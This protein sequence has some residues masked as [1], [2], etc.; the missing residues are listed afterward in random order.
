MS[1]VQQVKKIARGASIYGVITVF[2]LVLLDG[3]LVL[4]GLFEP[5]SNYG[6]P[7]VG[8]V[9]VTPT[10]EMETFPCFDAGSGVT[11]P[12]DRNERGYRTS[13]SV[14]DLAAENDW[15]E[16]AVSGDSHTDQCMT[17]EEMH[18]GVMADELTALGTESVVFSYGAGRYS[19]LQ[20]YLAVREGVEDFAPDA[21]VINLYTGNDFYDILRVDDRPHFVRV[22]EG[23]EVAPPVWYEYDEPGTRKRS[24]V[25]FAAGTV[26]DRLGLATIWTRLRYLGATAREQGSGPGSVVSYILD[27]RKATD[28]NAGYSAA[29]AAQILNQQLFF[30]RFPGSDVESLRRLRALMDMI[31]EEHPGVLLVM[32]PIPSY[33]L[34]QGTPVDQAFLDVLD[35]LPVTYEDGVRTEQQLFDRL[36]AEAEAAGWL[37]VDN[38]SPLQAYQGPER[39][40][41]DFDYHVTL[42]ANE[43]IGRNEAVAIKARV[44][45]LGR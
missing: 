5:P 8:W 23:Y 25:L 10:G 1:R 38:L 36:K 27:L 34:V 43:I 40:Y 35:K 37:F 22:G 13:V 44:D 31:R 30:Y 16:I 39:L 15:F 6:H 26:A 2:T 11:V 4:T 41:N 14:V 17:N 21:L 18:F 24:R 3:V 19:P 28:S 12:I 7:A 32:S 33:Q 45:T 42:K 9:S 29:F 20:E